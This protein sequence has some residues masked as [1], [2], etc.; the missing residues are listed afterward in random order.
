MQ[1]KPVLSEH[2]PFKFVLPCKS[3][4]DEPRCAAGQP[5]AAPVCPLQ[6]GMATQMAQADAGGTVRARRHLQVAGEN[7]PCPAEL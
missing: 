1:T 2:K 3:L 6:A 4:S 5:T 7:M